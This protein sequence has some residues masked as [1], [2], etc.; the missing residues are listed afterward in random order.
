MKRRDVLKGTALVP[1]SGALLSASSAD[2][3]GSVQAKD[4][5][6]TQA[7]GA[8]KATTSVAQNCSESK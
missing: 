3:A 8:G 4:A 7:Q 1:F 2:Q 6:M 5:N